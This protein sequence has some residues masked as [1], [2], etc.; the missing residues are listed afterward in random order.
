[1]LTLCGLVAVGCG[2]GTGEDDPLG[3]PAA[4]V[5]TPSSVPRLAD[6]S[7]PWVGWP[8]PDDAFQF[9]P[10]VRREPPAGSEPCAADDLEGRLDK[11]FV[12][13]DNDEGKPRTTA[14]GLFSLIAVRKVSDDA[15]TLRGEVPARLL[16][17]GRPAPVKTE[18]AVSDDARDRTTAVMPGGQAHLR[19]DWSAPYCGPEITDQSIE[20]DL[21]DD[22]GLVVVPVDEPLQPGCSNSETHP[23]LSSVFSSGVFDVMPVGHELNSPFNAVT[24]SI[25]PPSGEV[26]RGSTLVFH[27]TLTN[28]TD[29]SIPFD[30]RPG[31]VIELLAVGDETRDAVTARSVQFLNT[32]TISDLPPGPTRFE[33]QVALPKQLEAGRDVHLNWRL[34]HR[35]LAPTDQHAGAF[36]F[37]TV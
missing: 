28:P 20:L 10:A 7:V 12:K 33:M 18:H 19:I 8:A 13:G 1:M 32:V 29:T 16:S 35:A 27:V 23:D 4:R 3:A 9:E 36:T 31:Y 25:D 24:A 15:C 21:P 30:P 2:G 17:G 14:N 6:G 26:P 5:T 11:W 22:G 34:L 37:R